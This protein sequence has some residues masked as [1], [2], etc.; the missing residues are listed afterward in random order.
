MI[1]VN[2]FTLRG[3]LAVSIRNILQCVPEAAVTAA[4]SRNRESRLAAIL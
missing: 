3:N 2:R 4:N 1:K